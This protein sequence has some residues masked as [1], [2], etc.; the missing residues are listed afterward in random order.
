[1]IEYKEQMYQLFK[2]HKSP[3]L[4]EAIANFLCLLYSGKDYRRTSIIFD[5]GEPNEHN[6]DL[7]RM[8]IF[9]HKKRDGVRISPTSD[10]VYQHLK[11]SVFQ[12]NIWA[13]ANESLMPHQNR[14][15]NGWKEDNGRDH[16]A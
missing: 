11:R 8:D 3:G 16:T 2:E 7:H 9:S 1:M 12:E 14:N 5:S 13:T 6:I 4:C 15:D 10:A